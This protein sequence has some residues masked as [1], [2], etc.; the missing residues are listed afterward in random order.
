LG[1]TVAEVEQMAAEEVAAWQ[2]YFTLM[3]PKRMP[4]DGSQGPEISGGGRKQ[5][6]PRI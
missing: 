1:L 6:R 3:N 5:N 4:P 2:V